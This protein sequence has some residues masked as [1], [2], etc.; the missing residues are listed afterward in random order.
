MIDNINNR[1]YETNIEFFAC[2]NDNMSLLQASCCQ[3]VIFLTEI[4]SLRKRS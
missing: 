1:M 3:Q 2:S 4:I